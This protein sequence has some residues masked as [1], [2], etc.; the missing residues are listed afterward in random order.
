MRFDIATIQTSPN[1][2]FTEKRVIDAPLTDDGRSVLLGCCPEGTIA[3]HSF[4]NVKDAAKF[5]RRS[6]STVYRQRREAFQSE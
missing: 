4:N 5:M 2:N 6:P 1:G 3:V